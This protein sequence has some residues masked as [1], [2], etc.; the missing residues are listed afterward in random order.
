MVRSVVVAEVVA[1]VDVIVGVWV[2]VVG[3]VGFVELTEELVGAV[4]GV[5][6]FR[7]VVMLVD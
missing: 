1:R 4:V 6:V 7:V 2:V 3:V 5:G